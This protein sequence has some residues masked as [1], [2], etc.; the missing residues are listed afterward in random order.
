MLEIEDEMLDA[1][2]ML[3]RFLEE[4]VEGLNETIRVACLKEVKDLG[5][6]TQRRGIMPHPLQR[7]PLIMQHLLPKD[8]FPLPI[9]VAVERYLR[10]Y[11]KAILPAHDRPI[12][13]TMCTASKIPL[14]RVRNIQWEDFIYEGSIVG[15]FLT[16]AHLVSNIDLNNRRLAEKINAENMQPAYQHDTSSLQYK[17]YSRWNLCDSLPEYCR[18]LEQPESVFVVLHP[19]SPAT[20]FLVH[21]QFMLTSW[22]ESHAKR[23]DLSLRDGVISYC[24]DLSADVFIELMPPLSQIVV[25]DH[26]NQSLFHFGSNH[27]IVQ[28]MMRLG[29]PEFA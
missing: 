4:P 1:L 22:I 29:Q 23:R 18:T 15:R 12:V 6:R 3:H 20:D 7:D 13:D 14:T 16:W 28:R 19:D 11:E 10:L 25:V 2:R 8:T 21:F 9:A 24:T 5:D 17:L 26:R 27:N